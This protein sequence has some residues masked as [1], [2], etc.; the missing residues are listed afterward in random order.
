M[1]TTPDD[2]TGDE[3]SVHTTVLALPEAADVPAA[4]E[5]ELLVV[6][7]G[8]AADNQDDELD[9]VLEGIVIP[10]PAV[11]PDP[12]L[13]VGDPVEIPAT[14]IRT[15]PAPAP[16]T[17]AT[18]PVPQ[19]PQAPQAPQ[20]P[21]VPPRPPQVPTVGGGH[22]SGSGTVPPPAADPA[23]AEPEQQAEP[24]VPEPEDVT[25][26]AWWTSPARRSAADRVA[27]EIGGDHAA[28]AATRIAPLFDLPE[29]DPDT[30]PEKKPTEAERAKARDAASAERRRR[31][32][33]WCTLTVLSMRRRRRAPPAAGD[34]RGDFRRLGDG[35]PVDR[36]R[37]RRVPRRDHVV[38][39]LVP[40]R[41]HP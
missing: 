26:P 9:T 3:P 33:R 28:K 17:P 4:S 13:P 5:W 7:A 12:R 16:P 2:E 15:V 31:F 27:W 8:P 23:D 20:V 40:A 10:A 24:D 34:G 11:R 6:G 18:P 37:L 36:D 22:D 19:A 29:A 21:P 39:R 35:R 30:K 32:R 25:P 38:R 14:V 1:T 41:R